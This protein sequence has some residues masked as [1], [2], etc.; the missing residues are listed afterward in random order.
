ME[1][2][3]LDGAL[4]T[5]ALAA[6]G[7]VACSAAQPKR[8]R[9]SRTPKGKSTGPGRE[10]GKIPRTTLSLSARAKRFRPKYFNLLLFPNC[11]NFVT[12]FSFAF[13]SKIRVSRTFCKLIL[14]NEKN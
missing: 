8:E 4:A 14:Q 7:R 12:E 9:C 1:C 5:W 11:A 10:A 3:G 2:A 6:T 13:L